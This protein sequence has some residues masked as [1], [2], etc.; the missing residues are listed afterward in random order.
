MTIDL[1]ATPI[2]RDILL[3]S[4]ADAFTYLQT[5]LT[6]DVVALSSGDSTWSFLLTPKSEIEELV[7]VTRDGDIAILDVAVGR[8]SALRR[9]LDGL[10]FRMKVVFEEAVWPGVAWRGS[11]ALEIEVDAPVVAPMPWNSCE[12]VDVLGPDVAVPPHVL[13]LSDEELGTLRIEEGWPAGPEI[14]GSVTPAMTGIVE[15]TVSFTKGCYTGQEFVARVHH[16]EVAPPR[17]LVRLAFADGSL[18]EAGT[19]ITID[20]EVVGAVTS[21]V[22]IACRGLGYVKR[23]VVTP[24]VGRCLEATVQIYSA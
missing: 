19:D 4:G 9:R 5:Q 24:T 7:R 23:S 17:R 11:G 16:R 22:M 21:T 15:H 10:L 18:I 14:D 12:A 8:G 20:D 13:S 1:T 3:V 2:R 6:Q